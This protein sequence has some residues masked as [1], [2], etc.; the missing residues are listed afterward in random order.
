[1]TASI[2]PLKRIDGPGGLTAGR[3][4]ALFAF[5]SCVLDPWRRE[6]RTAGRVVPLQRR[7]YD[8]LLFLVRNPKRVLSKEDLLQEIWGTTFLSDAVLSTAALKLR[9][10]IGDIESQ[11][12][13][14]ATVRGVGYRLDAEVQH[15]P[16]A[17]PTSMGTALADVPRVVPFVLP[18]TAPVVA[19]VPAP[20]TAQGP[21]PAPPAVPSPVESHPPLSLAGVQLALLRCV[22]QTGQSG[23]DWVEAGLPFLFDLE[24]ASHPALQLLPVAATVAF[25]GDGGPEFLSLANDAL[26]AECGVVVELRQAGSEL[27]AQAR[28][29]AAESTCQRWVGAWTGPGALVRALTQALTG[30]D[31]SVGVTNPE[32]GPSAEDDFWITQLARAFTLEQSGRF[33]DALTLLQTCLP[34]LQPSPQLTLLEVRL[35]RL[36]HHFDQARQRAEAQL[37]ALGDNGSATLRVQ[38]LLEL[39]RISR[40]NDS[41]DM[42]RAA[43]NAAVTLCSEQLP[44]SSLIAEACDGLSRAEFFKGD[45][46][47]AEL[48]A[49]RALEQA[50]AHGDRVTAVMAMLSLCTAFEYSGRPERAAEL[51]EQCFVESERTGVPSL[52]AF[53]QVVKAAYCIERWQH[54]RALEAARR[55]QALAIEGA[56]LLYAASGRHNEIMALVSLGRLD[57]ASARLEMARSKAEGLAASTRMGLLRA[58]ACLRM[59][60]GRHDEALA[61]FDGALALVGQ[62]NVMWRQE[63]TY[64]RILALLVAGRI[65]EVKEIYSPEI[66]LNAPMR[67]AVIEAALELHAGRRPQALQRLQRFWAKH[68]VH[69]KT[70]MGVLASLAWMLLED[71]ELD[72][73]RAL[74]DQLD[75]LS[76]DE[77]CVPLLLHARDLLLGTAEPDPRVWMDL[78]QANPGLRHRHPWILEE[79]ASSAWCRR[80]APRLPE[81]FMLACL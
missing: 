22:N 21:M 66:D 18:V 58:E 68:P 34:H 72:A 57:E 6:L 45:L 2:L 49:Q 54:R 1:M 59:R 24:L 40:N 12:P 17:E 47:Q 14:L 15:V 80:E 74:Q 26:G 3:D 29:G 35:L 65:D 39:G 61:A 43:Y 56:N 19:S 62:S 31:N 46:R 25:R 13:M 16:A 70:S 5:G 73:V 64:P 27:V 48:M 44:N 55:A 4:A 71:G 78:A 30:A 52:M 23:L 33:E 75:G 10:A 42:G 60:Q 76:R 69:E 8:L 53:N 7:V 36:R 20:G 63:L 28:W 38:L 50:A 32:S 77:T 67:N 51:Y 37:Q 81:L 11:A 9:K 41:G 79:G